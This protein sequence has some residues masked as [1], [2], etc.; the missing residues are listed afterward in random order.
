MS[1][2]SVI[3]CKPTQWI[4]IRA[5]LILVMFSVFAYLFYKDGAVGYRENNEH[6]I[7]YQLFNTVAPQAAEGVDSTDAWKEY[8][9]NQKFELPSEK[10]CPLPIDF[11]RNQKWPSEL[12]LGFDKLKN[13]TKTTN[14]LWR[15][16]AGERGWAIETAD[17]LEDQS[18]LNT[19]FYMAY[20]CV[21]IV[22]IVVFLFVRTLTRTME[23]TETSYIAPG[24][25]KVPFEAMRRIDTRKWDTKGMIVIEYE[26]AGRMKKVKVDGMI[27]GQFKKADG[28]PAERLYAFILERFKGELIEFEQEKGSENESDEI[29]TKVDE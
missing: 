4:K 6:F 12:S 27:Y 3:V 20:G 25:T 7:Y 26:A 8:V 5:V 24:G 2:T 18:S 29:A 28:E 15:D 19:Q 10:K 21:A 11:D 13:S 23:V 14:D 9:A 17:H 22:L 16:F 1:E